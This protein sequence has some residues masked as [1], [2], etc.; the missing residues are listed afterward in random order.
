[1]TNGSLTCMAAPREDQWTVLSARVAAANGWNRK[2]A[3]AAL[4]PFK[5]VIYVI[6]ENR[7]FDQ[8][9]GDLAGADGDTS[10]TFFPR[11]V[12]PNA[13][14]LADRFGA[15]DRF[16]VNA[17]VSGDGHNWTTAAYASDYVE[18]TVASAYSDRGRTYDYDGLNHDKLA[19][20]DV[21]EPGN[22]Y[23]WDLA[24]KA[25][26]SLRN[27]GEFTHQAPDGSWP[28]SKPWLAARTDT[29]YPGWDLAISDTVRAAR[30]ISEF[31]Q[32]MAGNSLPALTILWLPNDHT[33]GAKVG[34]PTPRAYVA[35]NDLAL[36]RI[37]EALTR[38][39]YWKD[40]VVF[41]LE[42]DAQDGPDHVDSHRSP[43]LVI[44]AYNRPG[45]RHRWANTTDVLATID[46]ILH[47]G[48]L[49]QF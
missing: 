49:S 42:D 31:E 9:F 37:V 44:S 25:G 26:V 28:A 23:L 22:G 41:V 10:L 38:S 16:F 40:T 29:K 17:E 3:L 43:L 8:V 21:N 4:P 1:Q 32:Q 2:P 5:P 20:D 48:A 24:R 6:R 14:A 34:S 46:G 7:T 39:R 30:W 18:K 27:Y 19:E 47:L 13:H 12:T 35:S 36:G 15:F 45:V 11:D 33:A